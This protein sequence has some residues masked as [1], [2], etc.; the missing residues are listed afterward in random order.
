MHRFVLELGRLSRELQERAD[1]A[2]N[3]KELARASALECAT[4]VITEMM[5]ASNLAFLNGM[6]LGS[7]ETHRRA[8][9]AKHIEIS[10][11]SGGSE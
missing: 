10:E 7:A 2:K 9:E 4:K 8:E 11:E 1:Q 6:A 5:Q 3:A